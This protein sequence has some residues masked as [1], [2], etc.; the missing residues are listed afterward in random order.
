M[1]MEDVIGDIGDTPEELVASAESAAAVREAL[2]AIP[3]PWRMAFRLRNSEGLDDLEIAQ[4]IEVAKDEVPR[5]LERTADVLRA[6]LDERG[7]LRRA[8]SGDGA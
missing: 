6:H 5:I 1:S 2:S 8:D 4:A 3:T 7:L